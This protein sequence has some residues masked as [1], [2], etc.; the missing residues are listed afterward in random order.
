[1]ARFNEVQRDFVR[2]KSRQALTIATGESLVP[3][4][5]E[6]EMATENK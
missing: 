6:I 4:L 1:M 2:T 3:S 5:A